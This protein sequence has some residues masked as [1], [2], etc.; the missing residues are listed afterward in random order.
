MIRRI[1]LDHVQPDVAPDASSALY[2]LPTIVLASVGPMRHEVNVPF[3][4]SQVKRK[5]VLIQTG[6]DVRW[7][8]EAYWEPGPFLSDELIFR[9]V[10]SGVGV[11]GVDF[12]I[13]GERQT[14]LI[15]GGKI[16]IVENL[17]DL[18]T[19]PRWG[20]TFCVLPHESGVRAYA[21]ITS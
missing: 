11:V 6:W 8:T 5:A 10:R 19:L 9:L 20:S 12:W 2:S 4:D 3:H 15:P 14:H 18:S 21:E 13:T 1:D 7:G 17:R 16:P